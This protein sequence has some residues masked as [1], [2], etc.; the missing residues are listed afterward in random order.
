MEI[1]N[2]QKE[3]VKKAVKAT[4]TQP[5]YLLIVF[6]LLKAL[7]YLN[8]SWTATILFPILLPFIIVFGFLAVIGILFGIVFGVAVLID[9]VQKKIRSYKRRR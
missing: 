3:Q 6:V 7:G 4:V 8:W 9:F 2:E 5:P 1:N